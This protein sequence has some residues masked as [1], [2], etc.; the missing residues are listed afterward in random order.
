M[1]SE[2]VWHDSALDRRE[3]RKAANRLTAKKSRERRMAYVLQLQ[4]ELLEAHEHIAKLTSE[5]NHL[6]QLK[7]LD[8]LHVKT[9]E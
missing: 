8:S 2:I 9:A 7:I 5:L 4:R 6:K 1:S 3:R